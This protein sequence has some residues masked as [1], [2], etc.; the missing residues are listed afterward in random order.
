MKQLN[1]MSIKDPNRAA[2]V[3][4]VN[5]VKRKMKKFYE[6]SGLPLHKSKKK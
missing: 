2:L 6:K 3:N 5:V 4:E 1:G